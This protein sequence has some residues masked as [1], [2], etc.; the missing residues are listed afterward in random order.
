MFSQVLK[1]LL[2]ICIVLY[3]ICAQAQFNTA[4]NGLSGSGNIVSLG[5]PLLNG[6][7]V[8]DFG[9]SN[10]SSS[11]LMK[12]GS[13]NYF[14]IANDGAVKI[15]KGLVMGDQGSAAPNEHIINYLG[16][17]QYDARGLK[18]VDNTSGSIVPPWSAWHTNAL[19][20]VSLNLPS[21][22]SEMA[23]P[24]HCLLDALS[25]AT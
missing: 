4:N 23:T 1:S 5:G 22:L 11:F 8:I 9:S 13:G 15:Y 14:S 18:L 17:Y 16:T 12:K 25:R 20:F 19:S 6:Q 7:T 2:G 3:G 10:S 24:T 21:G